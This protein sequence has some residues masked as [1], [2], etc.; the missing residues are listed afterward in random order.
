[1]K[2]LIDIRSLFSKFH[3]GIPEY[4]KNLTKNLIYF[5]HKNEYLFF[6]NNFSSQEKKIISF[7]PQEKTINFHIPNKIFNLTAK[8]FSYPKID[9]KINFD[10]LLNP[11]FNLLPLLNYEKQIITIH[12]LSFI[13]F[14]EF[15]TFKKNLW[16][17]FQNV[18][19]QCK[20]SGLILTVSDFTKKTIISTFK[21]NEEKIKK[22]YP[23]I[24]NVYRRLDKNNEELKNFAL[25][26]KINFPFILNVATIEPR[27]NHLGLI[28]A[29]ELLKTKKSFKDHKLILVGNYGW[30][31]KEIKKMIKR[32]KDIIIFN[33]FNYKNMLFLYNLAE[34]FVFPSFFEGFGFPPLEAQKCGLPVIASNR[35]SLPEILQESAILIDPYKILD[36]AS[37]IEFTL[38]NNKI[39]NE[40]ILKGLKNSARF[41]CGKTTQ[42]ILNIF[43]NYGKK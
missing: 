24:N 29:F 18:K 20:K 25:Q 27:K 39:K 37:A 15:F 6:A 5:D 33:N 42:N 11:H 40:L 2:I 12:D 28:K 10:I 17:F 30:K 3:S 34:V 16:H 9:K 14:K 38:N 26:Y 22:V 8:I 41:D 23:G 4:T 19:E 7:I 43:E 32:N 21:I 1:M 36:L 35:T 13:F 31:Y